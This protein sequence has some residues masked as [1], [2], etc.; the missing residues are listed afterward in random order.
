MVVV[1]VDQLAA[2]LLELHSDVFRVG[3]RR[4]LDDGLR[5]PDATHDHGI[6]ETSPGHAT[7]ATGT[8]PSLHGMVSNL[9]FVR[10]DQGVWSMVENVIDPTVRLVG[11]ENLAGSSPAALMQPGLGDWLVAQRPESRVVS[12]SGKDRAAILLAGQ[13][14]H[15]VYWFEP[16]LARFATSTYY[17]DEDPFWVH[18]FNGGLAQRLAADSVWSLDV[19]GDLRSRTRPDTASFEGDGIHTGFP[20]AYRAEGDTAAGGFGTWWSSTPYLDRETVSIAIEAVTTME[21]GRGSSPDLLT[22]SLSS[23]DRVG[24]A[25]GPGSLEQLDNLLRLDRE[26]GRLFEAL[27]RAVGQDYVVVLTADHG[28]SEAPEPLMARGIAARRLTREEASEFNER[29]GADLRAHGSDPGELATALVGTARAEDWIAGAWTDQE[30]AEEAETD[31][32]AALMLES[33]YPGRAA[34]L[35]SRFGVQMMM[36]PHT[37]LW[38]W[39]RGTDHGSPYLYDRRVPLLFMGPGIQAGRRDGHASTRSIAPTLAGLL[40]LETPPAALAPAL[41]IR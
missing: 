13:G 35:L 4:L 33:L 12:V 28:V 39:P 24:H 3:F 31:S 36:T 19:P 2:D 27:D 30:L 1:V 14:Q 26:L 18:E 34:G 17:S 15:F 41:R 38:A 7:I 29:A 22:I 9:W 8:S 21:L 6:T 37:L 10:D 25:Y 40:G 20:H 5:F 23:T 11:A 32:L 16:Q